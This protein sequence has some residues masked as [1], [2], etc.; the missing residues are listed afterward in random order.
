M[1]HFKTLYF[2]GMNNEV[3]DE[4]IYEYIDPGRSIYLRARKPPKHPCNG[5]QQ[6]KL[7]QYER[8]SSRQQKF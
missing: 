6:Q 4:K 3:I 8:A 1:T 7:T 5:K 2:Y